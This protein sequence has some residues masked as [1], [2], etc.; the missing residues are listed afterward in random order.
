MNKSE[1]GRAFVRIYV[2]HKS[3]MGLGWWSK[4][5]LTCLTSLSSRGTAHPSCRTFERGLKQSRFSSLLWPLRKKRDAYLTYDLT[6]KTSDV[7]RNISTRMCTT[8][9]FS[10]V[11][12]YYIYDLWFEMNMIYISL[13]WYNHW[14]QWHAM[15]SKIDYSATGWNGC[16]AF[17]YVKNNKYKS[18]EI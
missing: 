4:P 11:F 10:Y 2:R 7:E 12:V 18:L 17:F 13:L 3:T 5:L 16:Q 8:S 6:Y 14:T 9:D 1:K 15:K